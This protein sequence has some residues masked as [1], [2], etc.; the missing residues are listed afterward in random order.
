MPKEDFSLI[1]IEFLLNRYRLRGDLKNLQAAY[2]LI[3]KLRQEI[4]VKIKEEK[5]RSWN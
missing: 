5:N 4:G 1:E 2:D 3:T